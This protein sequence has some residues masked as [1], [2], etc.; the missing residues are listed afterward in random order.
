MRRQDDLERLVPRYA[1]EIE[2]DLGVDR[3][4]HD[5]ADPP[6]VRDEAQK[7]ADRRVLEVN[8]DGLAVIDAPAVALRGQ[9]RD[10]LLGDR[11]GDGAEATDDG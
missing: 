4:G 8:I 3:I 2:R 11:R 6:G 7:I 9:L 1:R 10:R 5:D